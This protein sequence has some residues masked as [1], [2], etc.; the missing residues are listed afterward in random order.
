MKKKHIYFLIISSCDLKEKKSDNTDTS[1]NNPDGVPV[2]TCDDFKQDITLEHTEGNTVDYIINCLVTVTNDVEVDII[3][4][5]IIEFG[6]DAGFIFDDNSTM[7]FYALPGTVDPVILR[8]N[9]DEPGYWKGIHIKSDQGSNLLQ[10]VEIYD[11]GSATDPDFPGAITITGGCQLGNVVVSKSANY[12]IYYAKDIGTWNTFGKVEI[13]KCAGYPIH[14]G[15]QDVW[16]L[17]NW[18]DNVF[19]DNN[20]NR[21]QVV[22]E[23][24]TK[25][26]RF[27]YKGIPYE[28]DGIIEATSGSVSIED[29]VEI[30]FKRGS[31]LIIESQITAWA[32]ADKPIHLYGLEG[33]AGSWQGIYIDTKGTDA[34]SKIINVIIADGGEETY[35][36]GNITLAGGTLT[37]N[38]CHISNSRTCGVRVNLTD[39]EFHESGNVYANN[40]GGNLCEE[41]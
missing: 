11:A 18:S 2:L 1:V 33:T 3:D 27:N 17:G 30:A 19:S 25:E 8:G 7:V 12:G 39:G 21:I 5:A 9:K 38:D 37:L 41:Y 23:E 10:G 26:T 29:G 14:I 32:D 34:W 24:V 31:R 6:K 16:R 40:Q 36:S 35:G 22:P 28:V 20:P 13:T 4:G 15:A